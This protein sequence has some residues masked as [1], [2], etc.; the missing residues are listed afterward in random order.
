[1]GRQPRE[2]RRSNT[3]F[4]S[5]P[6]VDTVVSGMRDGLASILVP[7]IIGFYLTGSLAYGDF[8]PGSSD[9]DFFAVTGH[10]MSNEERQKV[11]GLHLGIEADEDEWA[12]RIETTY[13]PKDKL[14]SID[15]PTEGRPYFNQGK[16]WHPDPTYG[17]EWLMQLAAVRDFGIALIGPPPKTLIPEI[18]EA[19]VRDASVQD[20]LKEW[21]P[22][23]RDHSHLETPHLRAFAVLSLCRV[24][25]R[26]ETGQFATKRA[27]AEWAVDR[28]PYWRQ[29]VTQAASWQHGENFSMPDDIAAFIRYTIREVA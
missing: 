5:F 11:E 20:L 2:N 12:G 7:N 26:Q 6:G 17:Y 19:R 1:M 14:R 13:V 15:P 9:I 3:K 23:I 25:Y 16:M 18:D 27:A 10:R 8:D 21:E 4:D 29:L 28:Y 24:L 22:A